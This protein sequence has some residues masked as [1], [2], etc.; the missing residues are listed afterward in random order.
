[1]MLLLHVGMLIK[2]FFL[3]SRVFAVVVFFD[4]QLI[5]ISAAFFKINDVQTRVTGMDD[6]HNIELVNDNSKSLMNP[7]RIFQ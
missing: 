4:L 2:L 1:M 7:G 3:G 6:M 5:I